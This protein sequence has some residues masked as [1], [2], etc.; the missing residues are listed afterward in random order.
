MAF[1]RTGYPS[2][3]RRKYIVLGVIRAAAIVGA[4]VIATTRD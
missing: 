4:I 2:S 1:C 3:N